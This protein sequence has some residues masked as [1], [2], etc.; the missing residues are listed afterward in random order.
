MG[1]MLKTIDE[2][3]AVLARIRVKRRIAIA[4]ALI[5]GYLIGHYLA[6]CHVPE[7]Q[8]HCP[9]LHHVYSHIE[10]GVPIYFCVMDK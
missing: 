5:F 10:D 2:L 3:E 6:P 4:F 8:I 1:D 7:P 9:P